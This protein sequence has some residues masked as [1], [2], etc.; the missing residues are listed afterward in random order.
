MSDDA[1]NRPFEAWHSHAD[2]D[3]DV[4]G[5]LS[6]ALADDPSLSTEIFKR[7]DRASL[8]ALCWTCAAWGAHFLRH[9][10]PDPVNELQ[11][12]AVKVARARGDDKR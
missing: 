6:C 1:Q 5:L 8:V 11:G 3:A 10:S 12:M 4:V 9:M 2:L 7:L